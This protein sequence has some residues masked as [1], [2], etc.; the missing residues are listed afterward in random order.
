M[1]MVT[2]VL[3]HCNALPISSLMVTVNAKHVLFKMDAFVKSV[4]KSY[5]W[6]NTYIFSL[7]TNPMTKR[8]GSKVG[9]VSFGFNVSPQTAE[10]L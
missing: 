4:L 9:F 7:R 8:S 3:V 6:S 2:L 1:P 5:H 10:V